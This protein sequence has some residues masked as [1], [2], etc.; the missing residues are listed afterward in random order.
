M[1][2]LLGFLARTYKFCPHG[3]E[4]VRLGDICL[5]NRY[6]QLGAEKLKSLKTNNGDI[7][8]LP[9]SRNFELIFLKICHMIKV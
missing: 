5:L 1:I 8:L 4:Y 7:H 2:N 6:K 3:V 9:S